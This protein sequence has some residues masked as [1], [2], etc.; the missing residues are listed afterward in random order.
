[1][2]PAR[3]QHYLPGRA[4]Q[5]GD[6]SG[7]YSRAGSQYLIVNSPNLYGAFTSANLP[8]GLSLVYTNYGVLLVATNTLSG[9]VLTWPTPASIVYGTA[10][11]PSQLDAQASQPGNFTYNVGEGALLGAGTHELFVIY[12]PSLSGFSPVTNAVSLLVIPAP[13]MV[14][15]N[16]FL[17]Q[18]GSPVPALTVSY[19]GLVAGDSAASLGGVPVLSTTAT[20]QSLAGTYP[21]TIS[22]GTINDPNYTYTFVPGVLTIEQTDFY[23]ATNGSD[24]NPGTLSQPFQTLLAAEL[25]EEAVGTNV[26]RNIY[27]RGGEYFN[28]CQYLEGPGSVGGDDS[29]VTFAG[30]S[31]E[32][33]ILYG[34]QPLTGWTL[35][36]NGLWEAALPAYPAFDP[37]VNQLTNWEVR[38]LLVDGQMAARAQ[39]PI[40]GS[41]LTYTNDTTQT[42]YTYI[43]YNPG[44][45][46]DTMV[47][48]N[49]E[50][51]LDFSWDAET[52]GVSSVDAVSR[53]INF[54]GGGVRSDRGLDYA[55]VQTY[56][57]YNTAE[58]LS[59]PGQFYFDRGRH[60]VV[61]W[62]LNGTDP[63]DSE[64]IAPTTDCMFYIPGYA[65]ASPWNITFSNLTLKV[66]A[67][68]IE[69]EYNYGGGWD[70]ESLI[71]A[72]YC[73][74][75][76]MANLTMGWCGGNAL[77]MDYGYCT[78]AV[79]VN[80]EIGYC[81]GYGACLREAPCLISN[82]FIH[83]T[84][85]ISWQSPAVRVSQHALVIQN[86][87][88]NS[89]ETAIGNHEM[90]GCT[91]TLNYISNAMTV[92]RDMGA[93]YTYFGDT[94]MPHTNG[95]M[96]CSNLFQ[97]H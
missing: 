87:I 33:A 88:F 78:N 36:S 97:H 61:Y 89:K 93:V 48:T 8:A 75:L 20:P 80:S 60:V 6:W 65:G 5:P 28:V 94:M 4:A 39:F 84:G 55:G 51:M 63:N 52:L 47:A 41:S 3:G 18:P 74:N 91:I 24:A 38:M 7:I 95:N 59:R 68:D 83:D 1:M 40:D 58:G 14:T 32:T 81:G 26:H 86:N 57:V 15:A 31:N 35:L 45:L 43:N 56:R 69:N 22:P 13:L 37:I 62:P 71:R 92:L 70:H 54:S 9:P 23:V 29:D 46:P 42:N 19:S 50:V 77:G 2:G 76:V 72:A 11:S 96:I 67:V 49:M 44:D 53:T 90:D 10:L 16:S 82:N 73:T 64:I 66:N 79:L 27:L 85:L 12:T 25:A 17:I 21:I 34:G 30:Y